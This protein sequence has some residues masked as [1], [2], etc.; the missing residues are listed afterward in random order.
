MQK[1]LHVYF[2]G[3]VQGIGFRY[4]AAKLAHEYEI[5][6]WVRNLPDGRV[7]VVVEGDEE[8]LRSFLQGIKDEFEGYVTDVQPEWSNTKDGFIGF[9][10]RR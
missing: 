4:T 8:T 5:A 6:G 7:E 1:R 3:S 2:Y 9:E 10:V